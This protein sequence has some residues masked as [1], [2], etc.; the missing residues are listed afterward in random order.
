LAIIPGSAHSLIFA[1][2]RQLFW[3]VVHGFLTM[4]APVAT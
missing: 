1:I 2:N 4:P 3:H